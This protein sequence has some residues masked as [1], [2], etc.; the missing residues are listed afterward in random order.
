MDLRQPALIV[1]ANAAPVL[2]HSAT[3][4]LQYSPQGRLRVHRGLEEYSSRLPEMSSRKEQLAKE[5]GSRSSRFTIALSQLEA[6]DLSGLQQ[7][8]D[9]SV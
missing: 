1:P 9:L 7:L 6:S 2:M 3:G 4:C 5:R 8:L